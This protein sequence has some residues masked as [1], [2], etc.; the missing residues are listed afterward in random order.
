[1]PKAYIATQGPKPKTVNDFW[2]MV[3]QE[4][5]KYIVMVANV[6]ENGKVSPF[7]LNYN[8]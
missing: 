2:R 4:N 6:N 3:W 7:K 5:A 8:I 1:M